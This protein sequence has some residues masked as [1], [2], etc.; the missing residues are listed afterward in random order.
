MVVV[1]VVVATVVDGRGGCDWCCG[2]FFFGSGDILF[3]CSDY[4]ILL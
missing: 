2:C 4:I 3:Y 1:L